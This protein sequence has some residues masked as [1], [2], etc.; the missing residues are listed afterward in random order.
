MLKKLVLGLLVVALLVPVVSAGR[1]NTVRDS[2]WGSTLVTT[3]AK[4]AEGGKW[5]YMAIYF[6]AD[7]NGY[8]VWTNGSRSDTIR[9]NGEMSY[10][11][12][13]EFDSVEIHRAAADDTVSYEVSQ[14]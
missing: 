12:D 4:R 2:V 5:T 6:H 8:V 3:I 1:R 11:T 13:G 9:F 14:D 7:A 10:N